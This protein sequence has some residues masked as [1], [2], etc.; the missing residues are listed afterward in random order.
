MNATIAAQIVDPNTYV[1]Q[2]RAAVANQTGKIGVDQLIADGRSGRLLTSHEARKWRLVTAANDTLH[3]SY[4]LTYAAGQSMGG[5]CWASMDYVGSGLLES[6]TLTDFSK[7]NIPIDIMVFRVQPVDTVTDKAAPNFSGDLLYKVIGIIKIAATDYVDVGAQSV[8][9]KT[10]V[11]PVAVD[12]PESKLW[13]V[14][15]ARGAATYV[16]PGIAMSL[17]LRL[18]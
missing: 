13:L 11:I 8:A 3:I 16:A 14:P 4:G 2:L 18:A 15:I 6:I 1:P 10:V 5:K 12:D 9:S 17:I 7:Q